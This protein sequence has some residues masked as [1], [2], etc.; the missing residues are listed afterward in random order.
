MADLQISAEA[1]ICGFTAMG[2]AVAWLAHK[3]Y[4]GASKCEDSNAALQKEVRDLHVFNRDILA[5]VISDVADAL[6]KL[7][8]EVRELDPTDTESETD[9]HKTLTGYERQV[10]E[11]HE[12]GDTTAIVRRKR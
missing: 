6:N 10:I 2:S 9:I 8:R 4:S 11:H 3:L 7:K 5:G 1:I 12:N